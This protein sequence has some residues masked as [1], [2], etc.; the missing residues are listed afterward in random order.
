M[1]RYLPEE[2]VERLSRLY[3]AG[4]SAEEAARI[5]GVARKTAQRYRRWWRAH[6]GDDGALFRL[7][8]RLLPVFRAEAIARCTTPQRVIVDLLTAVLEDGLIN[9][10]LC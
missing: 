5:E 8:D 2:K 10:I 7:P 3:D 1:S 6:Q 4:Y 9:L